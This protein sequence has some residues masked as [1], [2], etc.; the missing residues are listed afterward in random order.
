MCLCAVA[1]IQT[2]LCCAQETRIWNLKAGYKDGSLALGDLQWPEDFPKT[3]NDYSILI[4]DL[5]NHEFHQYLLWNGG[6]LVNLETP[7]KISG[8]GAAVSTAV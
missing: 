5:M 3:P 1:S 2:R 6:K 4:T 8:K 7:M